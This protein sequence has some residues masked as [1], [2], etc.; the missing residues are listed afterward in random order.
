MTEAEIVRCRVRAED[1]ING[2]SC[3][4]ITHAKDVIR[5]AD[6]LLVL[7]ANIKIDAPSKPVQEDFGSIF[8]SLM[9]GKKP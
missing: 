9:K 4:K 5:L 1:V 6:A 8:E 2:F 7:L 3:V